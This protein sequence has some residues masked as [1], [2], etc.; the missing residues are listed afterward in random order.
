MSALG[1]SS[2][3]VPASGDGGSPLL[4]GDAPAVEDTG[5]QQCLGCTLASECTQAEPLDACCIQVAAPQEALADGVDLHLYSAPDAAATPALGCLT[6][7]GTL[8]V[9]QM[10]TLTGYVRLFASGQ[11]SQGV[12]VDVFPENHPETPD[13]SFGAAPLGTYTTTASD[14][15]DPIDTT[16]NSQCPNG[17]SYRQ[18]A[19]QN[20][21][22][23]TPLV[24]RTRDADSGAW[25]TVYEYDVYLQ[26][27]AVQGGQVTY[28]ATAAAEADLSTV[29]GGVGLTPANDLGLLTGEV[30]DC[31]DVRLS[32]A[33]VE[34]ESPQ[35]H[36]GPMIY[37]SGDESDP[38]PSLASGETSALGRFAAID[39]PPGVPLRLSAVGEDPSR[40]GQFLMLGTYVI[41]VFPGAMTTLA[42]RGRRPWQP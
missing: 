38:L 5:L 23:E 22:T 17:C 27:A 7:P 12:E 1:C 24:V 2:T 13:G 35:A 14:P 16:W 34:A 21:P 19:I 40:P 36:E 39:M 4:C 31:D 26:N 37:F 20:V 42:L 30:H 8:G 3:G 11:D 25:A 33:T 18:Y 15:V 28:D 41:Q 9:P 29:A 10:V 32:G 6:Q